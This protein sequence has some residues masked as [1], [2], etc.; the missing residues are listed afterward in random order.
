ML[1]PLKSSAMDKSEQMRRVRQRGSKPELVVRDLLKSLGVSFASN[2]RKL[3]GTP[4]VVLMNDRKVIFVNGCFWHRHKNCP[5]ASTPGTRKAFWEAKFAANK[6][7]DRRTARELR[8]LGYDVLVVWECETKRKRDEARLIRKL[9]RFVSVQSALSAS[10]DVSRIADARA[11]SVVTHKSSGLVVAGLFAG[12]GGIELGLKQAGHNTKLLVEKDPHAQAVLRQNFPRIQLEDDVT[13]LKNLPSPITLLT[14]GFPCQDLSQAGQTK[15]LFGKQ[16]RLV[17]YVF[18]L[19]RKNRIANVL[20]ENVP[21]MLRLQRGAA[22]RYVLSELEDLGYA[23]AYRVVDSRSFGL[24]QRRQRVFILASLYSDP[25]AVLLS[26]DTSNS[27][28]PTAIGAA[29]D[30]DEVTAGGFYWTEGNRGVGFVAQGIP[31]LKGG[32]TIGILP[33]S[34]LEGWGTVLAR[35]SRRRATPRFSGGLDAGGGDAGLWT[36]SVE[37]RRQCCLRTGGQVDRRSPDK[38]R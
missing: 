13:K 15:G 11:G 25:R 24:P 30:W 4:D 6:S 29:V 8:K 9:K 27:H 2:R 14:A 19:L 17:E 32:S 33:P 28:E 36:I 18:K 3:P 10:C 37:T 21:F 22:L 34:D 23:W 7:R 5:A 31:P 20:I 38:S 35:Y 26:D 12:I 1:M 16:S